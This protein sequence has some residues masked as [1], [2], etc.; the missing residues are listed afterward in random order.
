MNKEYR[1]CIHCDNVNEIGLHIYKDNTRHIAMMCD[2]C[3]YVCIPYE[4]IE[5]RDFRE[6]KLEF[7]KRKQTE[8]NEKNEVKLERRF[9]KRAKKQ[10]KKIKE[11]PYVIEPKRKSLPAS[12]LLK[13]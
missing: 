2:N 7:Y 9:K 4:D 11:F 12:E 1:K 5:L 8:Y 13:L 3:S 10:R 6:V